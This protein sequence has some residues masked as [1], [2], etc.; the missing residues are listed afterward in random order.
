MTTIA[1]CDGVV[2]TD[3]LTVA[4]TMVVDFGKEKCIER[5]GVKFFLCG[6]TSDHIKLVEEYLSPTDRDIGDAE[7]IVVDAGLIYVVGREDGGK[8]IYK[9]HNNRHNFISLGSGNRFAV[10]AMDHGKSAKQAV[11]YAMKRDIYTGG[12]VRVYEV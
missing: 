9:C 11:E 7:A 1:Y 10:A 5:D 12:E 2:A 6:C 4:G 3:T 8:G